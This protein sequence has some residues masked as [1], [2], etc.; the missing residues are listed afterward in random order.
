MSQ[1]KLLRVLTGS[2]L[3][4]RKPIKDML[5]GLDMLS[6]NQLTCQVRLMEVW[7]GINVVGYPLADM[8]VCKSVRPGVPNTRA[9]TRSDLCE[10]GGSETFQNRQFVQNLPL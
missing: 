2:K 8:F 4:D 7:K 1:N 6:V 10:F 9:T 3:S 5:K